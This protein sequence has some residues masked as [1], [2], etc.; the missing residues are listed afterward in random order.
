MMMFD[1]IKY[2]NADHV[3]HKIEHIL[4]SITKIKDGM[5]C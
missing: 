2:H 5:E 3:L 4:N 1:W